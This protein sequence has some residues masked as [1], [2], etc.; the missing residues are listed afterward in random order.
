MHW[1][2]EEMHR[3]SYF[4]YPLCSMPVFSFYTYNGPISIPKGGI[5]Q[6]VQIYDIYIANDSIAFQ[7]IDVRETATLLTFTF[8]SWT[9]EVTYLFFFFEMIIFFIQ[10]R[11]HAL[12][13]T[14]EMS[15]HMLCVLS[16]QT[17][18]STLL[19]FACCS[20]NNYL[21]NFIVL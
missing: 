4:K 15:K 9:E 1:K 19:I 18:L 14:S 6:N 21:N 5:N 2:L 3:K 10:W 7:H 11:L 12:C 8:L 16:R 20:Y 13:L 17:N